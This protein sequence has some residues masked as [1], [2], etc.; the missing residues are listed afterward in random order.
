VPPSRGITSSLEIALY[1][2]R[3]EWDEA[4]GAF[5]DGPGDAQPC[6]YV[7]AQ[8][9]AGSGDDFIVDSA[10]LLRTE[11]HVEPAPRIAAQHCGVLRGANAHGRNR[12]LDLV[13]AVIELGEYAF[14]D[15]LPDQAVYPPP[16]VDTLF[17]RMLRT[18]PPLPGLMHFGHGPGHPRTP[19]PS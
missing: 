7:F 4:A 14:D 1:F 13:V 11:I 2:A 3:R 19:S 10:D 6:L 9:T 16:A 15:V 18:N 5:V 8:R 12:A 17:A